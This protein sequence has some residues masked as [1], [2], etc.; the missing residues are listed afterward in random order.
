MKIRL[1]LATMMVIPVATL[2]AGTTVDHFQSSGTIVN[3]MGIGSGFYYELLAAETTTRGKNGNTLV[4]VSVTVCNGRPDQPPFTCLTAGGSIDG[5]LLTRRENTAS[6]NI[7]DAA[8]AGLAFQVCDEFTCFPGA[9]PSPFPIQVTFQANGLF[10]N[11]FDGTNRVT[12]NVGGLTS[13]YTSKGKTT[14]QSA[15]VQGQ[16]GHLALPAS[17]TEYETAAIGDSKTTTH[18]ILRETKQ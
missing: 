5:R 9:P 7:A 13:R 14:N 6:L 3:A 1:F 16:I 10:I 18:V 17:G 11:E 2:Q 4:F 8:A 15:S 12:Q